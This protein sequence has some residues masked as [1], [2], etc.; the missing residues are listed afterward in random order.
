[1]VEACFE[2]EYHSRAGV[3]QCLF[4]KL[5]SRPHS[6]VKDLG[7]RG[8]LAIPEERSD[9]IYLDRQARTDATK[10]TRLYQP[11]HLRNEVEDIFVQEKARSAED[12]ETHTQKTVKRLY[13]LQI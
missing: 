3:E 6:G 2:L 10:E 8:R 1:M 12:F 5:D 11:R 7:L 9:G 13:R 4:K